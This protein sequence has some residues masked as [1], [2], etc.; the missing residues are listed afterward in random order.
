MVTP[1][2]S[3]DVPVPPT[4]VP[5]ARFTVPPV[6]ALLLV[7]RRMVFVV[8]PTESTFTFPLKP[9][10]SALKIT[11]PPPVTPSASV[12]LRAPDAVSVLP[13]AAERLPPP[14]PIAIARFTPRST[15]VPVNSKVEPPLMA[16]V[17]V[18][19]ASPRL[20]EAAKL[21]VPPVTEATPELLFAPPSTKVPVPDFVKPAVPAMIA[22]IVAVFA[23]LTET[24]GV[25][26]A[27]VST[28]A[29]ALPEIV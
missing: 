8:P 19:E 22:L 27:S 15:V 9:E 16:S 4:I 21:S 2:R 6:S 20:V 25:A 7:S 11:V 24:V 17:F 12:P 23:P 29:P 14:E 28:S 18:A 5:C 26:P 13:L 10:L 1:T 3:S